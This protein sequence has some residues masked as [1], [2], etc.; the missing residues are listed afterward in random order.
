MIEVRD[1]VLALEGHVDAAH[2]AAAEAEL[3][4][5]G[6]GGDRLAPAVEAAV[7]RYAIAAELGL[8]EQVFDRRAVAGDGR[9]LDSEIRWI[10]QVAAVIDVPAVVLTAERLYAMAGVP[11]P[12]PPGQG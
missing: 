12:N 11:V 4:A 7:L 6:F 2:V 10:T 5:A 3:R 8:R 1:S 9:D